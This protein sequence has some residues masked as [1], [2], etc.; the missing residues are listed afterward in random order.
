MITFVASALIVLF[1]L[2]LLAALLG[3]APWTAP[4]SVIAIPTDIIVL[5][6]ARIPFLDSTLVN[7]LTVAEI[8]AFMIVAGGSLFA[9]A[10][11]SLRRSR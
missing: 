3:V 9:L 4:W 11:L 1:G 5:P 2:R 7:R 6:L 8:L 10:S